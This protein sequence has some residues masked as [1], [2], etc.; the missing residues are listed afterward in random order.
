M[1]DGSERRSEG[2]VHT[3]RGWTVQCTGKLIQTIRTS[4]KK[5]CTTYQNDVHSKLLKIRILFHFL[6]ICGHGSTCPFIYLS[7]TKNLI[8][9]T[10]KLYKFIR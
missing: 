4:S 3:W 8:P 2:L 10:V 7:M 9:M 6:F 1:L 5:S